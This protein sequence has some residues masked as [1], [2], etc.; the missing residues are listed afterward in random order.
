MLRTVAWIQSILLI[1][2]VGLFSGNKAA[3]ERTQALAAVP[4]TFCRRQGW[5]REVE[6]DEAIE[7][8]LGLEERWKRWKDREEIKRLGMGTIVSHS[9]LFFAV[10]LNS[11]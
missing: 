10:T 9:W 1:L 7:A 4:V 5:L 2:H 8:G 11:H 6:E 3:L